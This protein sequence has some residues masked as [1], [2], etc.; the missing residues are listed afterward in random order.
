MKVFV[1]KQTI[2]SHG[3]VPDDYLGGGCD[4]KLQCY[5]LVS[6]TYWYKVGGWFG[7]L[8]FTRKSP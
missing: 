7:T 2:L 1:D 5:K 3:Q 4:E 6:G 8:T